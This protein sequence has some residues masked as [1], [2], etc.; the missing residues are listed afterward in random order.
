MELAAIL[1]L[2]L[3][4]RARLDLPVRRWWARVVLSRVVAS[5]VVASRVAAVPVGVRAAVPVPIALAGL[6]LRRSAGR[7]TTVLVAYALWRIYGPSTSPRVGDTV[8]MLLG[9]VFLFV[10]LVLCAVLAA[11]SG[12]DRHE[13][14]F[15]ALPASPRSR[16]LGWTCTLAVVATLAYLVVVAGMLRREGSFVGAL[17]GYWDLA[18]TPAI[19]LGGGMLGLLFARLLPGWLAAPVAVAL[20]MAWVLTLSGSRFDLQMLT[21]VVEWI[22]WR[23]DE[24]VIYLQ[25]SLGWHNAYLFGLC[26]LGLVAALLRE[27]GPRRTLVVVGSVVLAGTVA[28]GAL[29][30]P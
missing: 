27:P 3:L 4:E 22:Q 11:T 24:V 10:G 28:A 5:R 15:G 17:P 8:N 9:Q 21:V 7:V 25:G 20:E 16:V 23:E 30:L 13:D 14:L 26:G 6:E 29:A 12:R 18:Q 19:V 1:A 2:V